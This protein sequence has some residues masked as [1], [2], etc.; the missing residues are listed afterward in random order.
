[1]RVWLTSICAAGAAMGALIAGGVPAHAQNA[2][3]DY[4]NELETLDTRGML[5][6]T[7][8]RAR[9]VPTRQTLPATPRLNA[10]NARPALAQPPQR[11]RPRTPAPSAAPRATAALR[12]QQPI[13]P[14]P[15]PVQ[16]TPQPAIVKPP[17][18]ETAAQERRRV[19]ASCRKKYGKRFLRAE[20]RNGGWTC[21]YRK[22]YKKRRAEAR[23][24]CRRKYGRRLVRVKVS[25]RSNKYTCY[26]R[27][28]RR[29]R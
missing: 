20:K 12:P 7:Q 13:T 27:K 28:S 9:F 3:N 25:R 29:R 17:P 4:L 15:R 14:P 10:D 24:I 18:R 2:I 5:P 6:R 11:L 22:S 1:M 21:W 26:F 19:R 16:P 8:R 23:R